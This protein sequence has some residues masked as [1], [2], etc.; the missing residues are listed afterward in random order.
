MVDGQGALLPV[1]NHTYLGCGVGRRGGHGRILA[2]LEGVWNHEMG[3][4]Q[5]T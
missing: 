4:A 2:L 1:D 3:R 5:L